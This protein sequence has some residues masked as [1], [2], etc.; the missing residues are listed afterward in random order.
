MMAR[1]NKKGTRERA[2][3]PC[4]AI[5]NNKSKRT[6]R[7][8]I[9]DAYHIIGKMQPQHQSHPPPLP[10]PS[11]LPLP[12]LRIACLE[13]SA[14]AICLALG[15]GQQIVG[16]THD[17]H[18]TLLANEKEAEK[19]KQREEYYESTSV[20]DDDHDHD[21]D[22]VGIQ[23]ERGNDDDIL[24]ARILSS[25]CRI[26]TRNGLTVEGQ[27][28]IH[29]AVV[30]SKA[31]SSKHNNTTSGASDAD[32]GEK[33][34]SSS[35]SS[36]S[37]ARTKIDVP[38]G[39]SSSSAASSLYPLLTEEW[40]HA[41]PNIVF[42]QDLCSVCAPTTRHVQ[43]LLQR[44]NQTNEG[45]ENDDEKET[46][47][48]SHVA[49]KVTT[50]T[51]A[52]VVVSLQPSTLHEVADTFVTIAQTCGVL[53]RGISLKNQFLQDLLLL[54]T[55]I[56]EALRM[57]PN[58]TT[59]DLLL[60]RLPRVFVFQ[61]L[62]PPFDSGHWTYQMMEY[63]MIQPAGQQ[64][65]SIVEKM[66]E[67][68]GHHLSFSPTPSFIDKSKVMP[69]KDVYDADPDVVVV[70]C[71]GF[72]LERNIRDT[73][74]YRH[75]L[76]PLRAARE[77]RIYACNGGQYIALPG[78][79]LVLG[80]V[81]LAV[82][83]YQDQPHVIQAISKLNF[84]Q[85]AVTGHPNNIWQAVNPLAETTTTTTTALPLHS[86]KKRVVDIEDIVGA[87]TAEDPQCFSKAKNG[88][89]TTSTSTTRDAQDAGFVAVHR[90]ACEAGR[91]TYTDPATGYQV[92]TEL[93]HLQR[94][95]CCGSGCRHCPFNHANV[96]DKITKIQQPAF[97]HDPA[98]RN[99]IA[100][101]NDPNKDVLFSIHHHKKIKVLFFSGGKDSFLT[102]RALVKLYYGNTSDNEKFG[103]VLM[104][105]FDAT[106][107][108]IAH[109]EVSIDQVVRQAQHLNLALVGIP[110]RRGSGEAYVDRIR[111]GLA[112]IQSKMD[113]LTDDIDDDDD[114][115]KN[116]ILSSG[117]RKRIIS[118][119]VFGDLHLS[120]IREWR[121]SA[122]SVF[123]VA[124]EY[125]VW[126]VPY[127]YLMQDL[128]DSKVPCIIS[129]STVQS[130]AVGTLF[131]RQFYNQVLRL[132]AE[133]HE[134]SESLLLT[135]ETSTTTNKIDGFGEQ[136]EFHSLAQVWYVSRECALGIPSPI[137]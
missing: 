136:G 1:G 133:K 73:L 14:T 63:A 115:D 54:Q 44:G 90:Q 65:V 29:K 56:R 137:R 50:T 124:L 48:T 45:D 129:A 135:D 122:L 4:K 126:N 89:T 84:A 75:Q 21:H 22:R 74:A 113:D 17:C 97:L 35:S 40:I 87:T 69:W 107:R 106:T 91:H 59:T 116:D 130:I 77:H 114:S 37:C 108:V 120:H 10:P 27:G 88:S 131:T 79:E 32:G 105:T 72:D 110:L 15:L 92:F 119:L 61:W 125:P 23:S 66:L 49:S 46:G 24:R 99:P 18:E 51:T 100:T 9:I 41:Q 2:T 64:Q 38:Q 103:L 47:D 11:P 58:S 121:E 111:Q 53:D 43:N 39:P 28:H 33:V 68:N 81:L 118:S 76:A 94:G 96:K 31:N 42:T 86:E 34:L 62:D 109:Q 102:I 104:T 55:T 5:G 80:T 7:Q 112:V 71:C 127:S 83:A 82:C 25:Q 36:L 134:S 52:T 20:D 67:N 101:W 128:E 19:Q 57:T 123:G 6:D 13:P 16:I 85:R 30:E 3:T 26:L 132:D 93:A 8:A 12:L 78:P 98:Q 60:P 117:P 70:G 95:K